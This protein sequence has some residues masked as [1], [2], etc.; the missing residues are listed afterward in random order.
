MMTKEPESDRT[1]EPRRSG[2]L[3]WVTRLAIGLGWAGL[4]LMNLW[5]I[6]A[7]YYDVRIG[8]LQ[9]PLAFA[10][11][12]GMLLVFFLV[13]QRVRSMGIALGGFMVVLG[14]WLSLR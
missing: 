12:A 13:K 6:G 4:A 5:V 14:W 1:A 9:R 8:W 2:S 11:G 7:L 10:Y 3:R